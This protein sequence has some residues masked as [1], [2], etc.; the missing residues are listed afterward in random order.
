MHRENRIVMLLIAALAAVVIVALWSNRTLTGLERLEREPVAALTYPGSTLIRQ[1]GDNGG[2][3]MDGP[4]PA[5][6]TRQLGSTDTIQAILA[7]YRQQMTDTGW[8]TGGGSSVGG[9]IHERQVCVWHKDGVVVRLSFWK[10]DQWAKLHPRDLAYT[11]VYEV[12]L[13]ESNPDWNLLACG[14]R[15]Y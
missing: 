6:F 12:A 15:A 9:A 13:L 2:S 3:G 7:F 11:T 10:P 1:G 14:S 5:S 4:V 8:A